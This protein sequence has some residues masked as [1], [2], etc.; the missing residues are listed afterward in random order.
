M[1]QFL[2]SFKYNKIN[3]I[4][5][6][7]CNVILFQNLL[8]RKKI[9]LVFIFLNLHSLNNLLIFNENYKYIKINIFL[10][11][12]LYIFIII[13]NSSLFNKIIYHLLLLTNRINAI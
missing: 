5:N 12:F 6:K 1:D 13:E 11:I 7:I 8:L 2:F 9:N 10:N 4:K 3:N